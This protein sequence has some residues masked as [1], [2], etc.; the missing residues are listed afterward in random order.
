M[1][2]VENETE[3]LIEMKETYYRLGLAVGCLGM[4]EGIVRDKVS[5]DDADR[6]SSILAR[7]TTLYKK[8]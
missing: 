8:A 1:S 5:A 7:I 3:H 6:I 2:T 4:V